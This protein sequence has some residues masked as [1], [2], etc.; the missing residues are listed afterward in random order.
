MSFEDDF[1]NLKIPL[2]DVME[3]TDDFQNEPIGTGGFGKVYK[4]LLQERQSM[5]AFKRLDCQSW[6]GDVEFW[7]E[8]MMLSKYKHN[9]LELFENL[10]R[11]VYLVIP[12]SSFASQS[13]LSLL[14]LKGILVGD[15]KRVI[16]FCF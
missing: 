7:K 10:R 6:Q 13:K 1:Q 15:G 4:G 12:P 5:V 16:T 11:I 14:L 3:A 2:K 8:I 9:N